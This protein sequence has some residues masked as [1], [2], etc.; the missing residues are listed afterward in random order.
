MP[1][2][3]KLPPHVSLK[4]GVAINTLPVP[5][6][7]SVPFGH[8]AQP[9]LVDKARLRDLLKERDDLLQ[10]YNK[11]ARRVVLLNNELCESARLTDLKG[12]RRA[13]ML[14]PKPVNNEIVTS[15]CSRDTSKE[16]QDIAFHLYE[17]TPRLQTTGRCKALLPVIKTVMDGE[18]W[19]QIRFCILKEVKREGLFSA[20]TLL[21]QVPSF[22]RTDH[23]PNLSLSRSTCLT[24]ESTTA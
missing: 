17:A 11:A 24:R 8:G 21:H 13:D 2:R 5:E 4:A 6:D 16:H 18:L 1:R 9:V 3:K 10:K 7:L 22:S 19:A 14:G 23:H 20:P 12:K 15:F